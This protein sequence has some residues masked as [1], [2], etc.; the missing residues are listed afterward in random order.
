E[1]DVD[2]AEVVIG[3]RGDRITG[4]EGL[5]P[6]VERALVEVVGGLVVGDRG[7]E[8]AEP[9][10]RVGDPRVLLAEERLALLQRRLEPL[11]R[12]I[13]LAAAQLGGPEAGQR[14]GLTDRVAEL[15]SRS[16]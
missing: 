12:L 9:I 14:V 2:E 8:V 11:A 16:Q 15:L 5:G 13:V 3:P 10:G 1:P 7:L 6:D 4:P